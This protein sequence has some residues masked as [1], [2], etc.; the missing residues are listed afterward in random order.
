M[1]SKASQVPRDNVAAANGI[2]LATGQDQQENISQL[3]MR[4]DTLE[5][6]IRYDSVDH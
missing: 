6:V 4:N 2:I 1:A 5:L 3:L